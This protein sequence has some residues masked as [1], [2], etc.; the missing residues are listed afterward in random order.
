MKLDGRKMGGCSS[1]PSAS[2]A[3]RNDS[4]ARSAAWPTTLVL[5]PSCAE[6][7]MTRP[8]SPSMALHRPVAR[9]R[10]PH[11]PR[12]AVAGPIRH[13][14]AAPWRECLRRD[15][16]SLGTNGDALVGVFHHARAAYA[17]AAACRVEHLVQAHAEGAQPDRVDLHLQLP[18]SPPKM[19]TFATPGVASR[20]GLMV[21]SA[22][23]RCSMAGARFRRDA[24]D[25]HG[26]RRRRQRR[27]DG[28]PGCPSATAAPLPPVVPTA[29]GGH[30]RR[31]CAGSARR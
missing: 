6:I 7:T 18:H 21:Q 14:H 19:A 15:T 30:D 27:D 23:V 12:R 1:S 2:M 28:L 26:A 25:E 5:P 17:R 10:R 9:R 24:R 3:G 29:P 31:R 11:V 16:L 8:R 20:R 13:A 22:K 4:R